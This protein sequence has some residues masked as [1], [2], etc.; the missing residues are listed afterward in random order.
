MVKL[1]QDL[2]LSISNPIPGISFNDVFSIVYGNGVWLAAGNLGLFR[3]VDDGITWNLVLTDTKY[4]LDTV[5]FAN[6]YFILPYGNLL[7]KSTDGLKWTSHN[8]IYEPVIYAEAVDSGSLNTYQATVL[9]PSSTSNLDVWPSTFYI[10]LSSTNT[11]TCTLEV[12]GWGALPIYMD[13]NETPVP[14]GTLQS[15]ETYVFYN[16]GL[17]WT[18]AVPS[19]PSWVTG[20][21]IWD[22]WPLN[23]I[24]GD[25]NGT[26]VTVADY[27]T[28]DGNY[29]IFTSTDL[30]TWVMSNQG[31][32]HLEPD[33]RHVRYI[34]NKFWIIGYQTCIASSSDGITWSV[35]NTGVL[36]SLFYSGINDI[37]YD[38][39][40]YFISVQF[41]EIYT[42]DDSETWTFLIDLEFSTT[43]Y[44]TKPGEIYQLG[45]TFFD[46]IGIV[47]SLNSGVS[48]EW[49][50][51]TT[52]NAVT[53]G[54]IN[55]ISGAIIL[56]NNNGVLTRSEN[57]VNFTQVFRESTPGVG[58]TWLFNDTTIVQWNDNMG[59][60]SIAQQEMAGITISHDDGQSWTGGYRMG[61]YPDPELDF[62][63]S[64][65]YGNG[66]YVWVG[67]N[68]NVT[69]STN[70]ETWSTVNVGTAATLYEIIFDG[71]RFIV[72]GD[73]VIYTSTDAVTWT[74][75]TGVPSGTVRAVASDGTVVLACV[76][77]A[78]IIR[79]TNGGTSFTTASTLSSISLLIYTGS[80][81]LAANTGTS[82]FRSTD[83]GSTW[84]T[85]ARDTN[86][87]S[88]FIKQIGNRLWTYNSNG[89]L[90]YSE[91]NG[92]T[93]TN[94]F[95]G[96]RTSGRS[97]REIWGSS[98][99]MFFNTG[100]NPS[101]RFVSSDDGDSWQELILRPDFTQRIKYLNNQYWI[102][103]YQQ[104]WHSLDGDNWSMSNLITNE[105]L[106][107]MVYSQG[108]YVIV[109]SNLAIFTSTDG[110]T[111]TW[112]KLAG[113]TRNQSLA[114]L[115]SVAANNTT[116]VTMGT[117]GRIYTSSDAITWTQRT[118][119]LLSS[120]QLWSPMWDGTQWRALSR[121]SNFG[122]ILT[123]VDDGETWTV[124]DIAGQS[125]TIKI[126]PNYLY[127][128]DGEYIITGLK[129]DTTS[130]TV[131]SSYVAKSTD[132]S[133]W[134]QIPFTT[135]SD[136]TQH[137]LD[138]VKYN[139]VYYFLGFYG[140]IFFSENL[141][142]ISYLQ[143][144]GVSTINSFTTVPRV[145][146][147]VAGD[148]LFVVG[149]YNSAKLR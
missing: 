18:W 118:S 77:Q 3:S 79:S 75:A 14:P 47:R 12:N 2:T 23:G 60:N 38:G 121:E 140:S 39:D 43:R 44:L 101:Q 66:K 100:N 32:P 146:M 127:Y 51:V 30:E 31:L 36:D 71:T 83:N 65:A 134:T 34:E 58:Y 8:P 29:P 62:L 80:V 25:G 102:L 96:Y 142:I 88:R 70:G 16:I 27:A 87:T 93:F 98:Q 33:I 135:G 117:L 106:Y 78:T 15:G 24:T 17:Y 136:G 28:P 84:T 37:A 99:G 9:R 85:I 147:G 120:T 90:A 91:D 59:Y 104:L 114:S 137:V 82:Y 111:W 112:V 81:W 67:A 115:Y 22:Y 52:Q 76:N 69:V 141:Q 41:G 119:P 46:Y 148:H 20:R 122:K 42:S 53:A 5:W 86:I 13:D 63:D 19:Q 21:L 72:G 125:A 139:N 74:A 129:V 89:I 94:K 26:Y 6:G 97:I 73:S 143:N 56:A 124:A 132:L 145:N 7:K 108:T 92:T 50:N 109:G 55:P 57:G 40:K 110:V 103:N 123:S 144:C 105:T 113:D 35:N 133:S 45:G 131:N 54:D 128:E 4:Q 95:L 49:I 68:G 11:D 149:N 48:W 130:G 1:V 61:F 107:D 116:F 64:G 10:T 138:M 126:Q